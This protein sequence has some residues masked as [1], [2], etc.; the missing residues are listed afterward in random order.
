MVGYKF[1][2]E[3][4]SF[5]WGGLVAEGSWY[6]LTL[7]FYTENRYFGWNR[8]LFYIKRIFQLYCQ[9]LISHLITYN[10][11]LKSGGSRTVNVK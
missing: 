1:L 7:Y 8:D 11:V 4:S 9:S 10:Y 5:Q 3:K 6:F 2:I